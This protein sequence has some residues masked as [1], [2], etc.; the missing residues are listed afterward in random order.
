MSTPEY[1]L[2]RHVH[3]CLTGDHVVFLD[4]RRDKYQAIGRAE[5]CALTE[6]TSSAAQ[7]R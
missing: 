5:R 4:L 3:L 1:Y 7:R 2:S 6:T